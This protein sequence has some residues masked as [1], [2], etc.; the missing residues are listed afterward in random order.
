MAKP[1]LN[2][3]VAV[4]AGR[5][6]QVSAVLTEAYHKLQKEANFDGL[7]RSYKPRDEAGEQ[8]AGEKK[9]P[10]FRVSEVLATALSAFADFLNLSL[11]LDTGNTLAKTDVVVDG[12]TVL[13]DVPVTSLLLLEKQLNDLATL[14]SKLPT[15][16]AAERWEY[17][18]GQDLLVAAPTRTVR[19]KKVK[20]VLVRY[21]AT[22]EHP[23]QTETY[24]D[25]VAVGDWTTSL[26]S[27]RITSARKAEIV[28]RV[29]RL[30]DAVKVARERANGIEVDKRTDGD[31]LLRFLFGDLMPK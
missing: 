30:R 31:G 6:A 8:L 20:K 25:D 7:V 1:K 26:F 28:D 18:A 3:I 21:E 4:T 2:E 16:D 15:P 10:Q 22:K 27:G 9:L 19:T 14:T 5:K 13:A 11:T 17:D 12:V 29:R 23:A 24:D